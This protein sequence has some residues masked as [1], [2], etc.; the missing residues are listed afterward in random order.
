[1]LQETA[2]EWDAWGGAVVLG[3]EFNSDELNGVVP[4]AAVAQ[5]KIESHYSVNH[6][7]IEENQIINNAIRLHD[8]P[9]TII[10]GNKDFMCPIE[11]S[12][13]LANLLPQAKLVSLPNSTHLAHGEEMIDALVS[14]AD[15]MLDG[16]F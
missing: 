12:Y 4:E 8:I 10:H 7:F 5:A 13:T 15:A 11:S 16:K 1:V 14:A 9:C 2:R 6:Y 3:E